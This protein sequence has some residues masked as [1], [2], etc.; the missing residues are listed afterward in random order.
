MNL[1]PLGNDR[2]PV[3]AGRPWWTAV[4]ACVRDRRRAGPLPNAVWTQH[5]E[6]HRAIAGDSGL[7]DVVAN[8]PAHQQP[9]VGVDLREVD[10]RARALVRGTG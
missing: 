4:E 10:Q 7:G 5:I 6:D 9:G 2:S 3:D 1:R 8:L